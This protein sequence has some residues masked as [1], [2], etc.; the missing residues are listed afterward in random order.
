MQSTRKGDQLVADCARLFVPRVVPVNVF[1]GEC[2]PNQL[3]LPKMNRLPPILRL[4]PRL[5]Q[6]MPRFSYGFGLRPLSLALLCIDW[7]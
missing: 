2:L 1:L 4:P 6:F 7:Q 3:M 5:I